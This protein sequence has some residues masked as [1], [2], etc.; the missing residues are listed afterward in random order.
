MQKERLL[1]FVVQPDL[2]KHQHLVEALLGHGLAVGIE[3]RSLGVMHV[4]PH[5]D[6][7]SADDRRL[8]PGDHI[9]GNCHAD[10]HGGEHAGPHQVAGTLA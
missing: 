3:S 8:L 10:Q 9:A 5:L 4:S 6:N 2:G 1:A 7:F